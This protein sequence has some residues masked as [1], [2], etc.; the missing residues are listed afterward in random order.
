MKKTGIP[1]EIKL[2]LLFGGVI[3]IMVL[4]KVFLL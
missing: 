2:F 1:V 4:V 3:A